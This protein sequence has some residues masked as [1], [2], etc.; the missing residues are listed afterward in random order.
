MPEA[1]VITATA[2]A[3]LEPQPI[4]SEWILARSPE[5]R[6]KLL[7]KS[8]DGASRIMVWEC[9]AAGSTGITARTGPVVVIAGEVF[10]TTEIGEERRLGE[11][12]MGFFPAGSSAIMARPRSDQKSSGLRRDLPGPLAFGLRAWYR[13]LRI[14]APS[15]RSSLSPAPL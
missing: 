6:A 7:A 15:G 2:A 12:D 4:P 14:V 3:D 9:T 10:V 13:L 1:I 5:A 8:H 11:G